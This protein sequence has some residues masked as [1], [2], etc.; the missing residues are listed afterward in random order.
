MQQNKILIIKF[1]GVGDVM[2][3]LDAMYSIFKKYNNGIT[4]LTEKPFDSFLK[5][6]RWFEE[7]VTIKRSLIYSYDLFQIKKKIKGFRCLKI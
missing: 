3:S 6:S 1:G 4:L 5:Q 7:I 2:L